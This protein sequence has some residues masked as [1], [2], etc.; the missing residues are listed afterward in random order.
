M[1]I[2]QLMSWSL[3]E[4]HTETKAGHGNTRYDNTPEK[5][6]FIRWNVSMDS[7]QTKKKDLAATIEDNRFRTPPRRATRLTNEQ[8]EKIA[9][10]DRDSMRGKMKNVQVGSFPR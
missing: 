5:C 1:V 6:S 7:P 4:K 8:L 9:R 3:T 10:E 2:Q